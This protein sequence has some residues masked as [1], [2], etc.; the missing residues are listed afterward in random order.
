V[1]ALRK[2]EQFDTWGDVFAAWLQ[3]LLGNVITF[4]KLHDKI[5]EAEEAENAREMYYWYG[6]FW[7]LFIN[8]EPIEEDTFE[9]EEFEQRG[10]DFF[11]LVP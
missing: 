4:Q 5:K 3:N 2:N 1:W 7:T 8:F 9:D 10:N 6:R 11:S